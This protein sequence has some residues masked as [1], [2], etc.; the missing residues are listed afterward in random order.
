M[1]DQF[2]L[3]TARVGALRL[4]ASNTDRAGA[5]APPSCDWGLEGTNGVR[6][7]RLVLGIASGLPRRVACAFALARIRRSR[8]GED[9]Q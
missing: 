6:G 4:L 5:T 2:S 1:R 7:D 3:L 8:G 9:A